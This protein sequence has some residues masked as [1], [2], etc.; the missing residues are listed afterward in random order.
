MDSVLIIDDQASVRKLLR[1]ILQRQNYTVFEA[2]DSEEGL[3]LLGQENIDLI[4]LDVMLKN[5]IGYDVCRAYKKN[6]HINHIPILFLTA[7]EATTALKD[8]YEAGGI[9]FIQKPIESGSLLMRIKSHFAQIEARRKVQQQHEELKSY[10]ARI[11]QEEKAAAVSRMVGG[12]S[13]ELNNPLACIKS[14]FNSLAKYLTKI[15]NELSNLPKELQSTAQVCEKYLGNCFDIVDE[16]KDEFT[17]LRLITDRLVKLDLPADEEQ[18]Y[19]INEAIKNV[20]TLNS[21]HL[22]D[23]TVTT[24]LK[25]IPDIICHPASIT[26]SI[27][28]LLDNAI[29]ALKNSKTKEIQISTKS[30]DSYITITIQDSGCGIPNGIISKIWDPFFTTREVGEGAGL[31]LSS[32]NQIITLMNGHTSVISEIDVGSTFTISI[33]HL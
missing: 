31:G 26:E 20:L 6:K 5:E 24:N 29:L 11:I 23:C 30:D 4:I 15:T 1:I 12:L 19:N 10:Q 33:P 2:T 7:S 9:D 25:K 22:K 8:A 18:S 21:T 16:S 3:K 32:I 17:Q 13:H 14:N 28:G 27:N